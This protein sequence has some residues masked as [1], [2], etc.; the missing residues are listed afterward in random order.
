MKVKCLTR[1]QSSL[2]LFTRTIHPRDTRKGL[3]DQAKREEILNLIK[4]RKF[5]IALES[6]SSLDPNNIPL[7]FVLAQQC[8]ND[9]VR[10]LK[11]YRT[12]KRDF[13]VHYKTTLK[14]SSILLL[15]YLTSILG[16]NIYSVD[17]DQA[18]LQSASRLG[19]NNFIKPEGIYLNPDE[20]LQTFKPNYGLK[21]SEVY[22]NETPRKPE[23]DWNI[24][25]TTGGQCL[26]YNRVPNRPV[27]RSGTHVDDF[28]R[29]WTLLL[30]KN[31][32]TLPV[33]LFS[34]NEAGDLLLYFICLS[35][36]E[37]QYG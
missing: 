25:A 19:R 34:N 4:R 17:V 15:L 27:E 10:N 7:R 29:A 33:E 1:E 21:D 36:R 20:M 30:F 23:G 24:C 28:F 13:V 32:R 8:K 12:G 14:S 11:G 26:F 5:K 35:I 31:L 2:T 37:D 9:S 6:D 16:I 18:H 22:W 3:L